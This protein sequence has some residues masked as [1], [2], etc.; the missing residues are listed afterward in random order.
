MSEHRVTVRWERKQHPQ[1]SNTYD[2]NHEADFGHDLRLI[3]SA[4]SAYL[5]DATKAD[6]EQLLVNALSSCH[7]LFFL[8]FAEGQGYTVSSYVDEAVGFV[9]KNDI[10]ALW[11]SRIELHPKPVFGGDKQPDA[12]TLKKIHHKAHTSCFINNSVKSEVIIH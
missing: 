1:R 6:P 3:V 8:A 7:M 10:G 11:V 12:E 5:G 4:A 2:R 9:E